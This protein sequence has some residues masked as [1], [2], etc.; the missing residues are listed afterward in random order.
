M[1]YFI[2]MRIPDGMNVEIEEKG[3]LLIVSVNGKNEVCSR[4]NFKS[5]PVVVDSVKSIVWD[6]IRTWNEVMRYSRWLS[7]Q[8]SDEAAMN[9]YK[10]TEDGYAQRLHPK[11]DGSW[12]VA[13]EIIR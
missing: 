3:S 5:T 6:E 11:H 12:Y 10:D 1:C 8:I 13:G 2:E 4:H 9:F 7:S